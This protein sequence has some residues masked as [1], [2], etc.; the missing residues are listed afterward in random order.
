MP[1]VFSSPGNMSFHDQLCTIFEFVDRYHD[2]FEKGDPICLRG[3]SKTRSEMLADLM[4]AYFGECMAVQTEIVKALC[5]IYLF[6]GLEKK[7]VQAFIDRIIPLHLCLAETRLL[8]R[9]QEVINAIPE[10]S[11]V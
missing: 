10:G 5:L 11:H 4:D 7:V 8:G 3:I 9:L 6:Y 2:P 1:N